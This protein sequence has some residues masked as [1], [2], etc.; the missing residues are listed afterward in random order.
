MLRMLVLKLD[1]SNKVTI[2]DTTTKE[3]LGSVQINATQN[4]Y[5]PEGGVKIA[6][7]FPKHISIIRSDARLTEKKQL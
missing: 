2:T 6:F 4:T 3:R 1:R 7:D 5:V